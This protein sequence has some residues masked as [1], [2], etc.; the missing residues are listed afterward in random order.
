M[1]KKGFT[2]IELMIV[3][4]IIGI[5]AAIAVPKF[6]ELIKKS[7]EGA[8]KGTLSSARSALRVYY[9]DN[10]AIYPA[11]P[12]GAN[13]AYLQTALVPKYIGEWPSLHVAPYHPETNTVDAIDGGDPA[14]AD[15]ADDGEWVYV[16]NSG[17]DEWGRL[18]IECYHADLKG[19]V[20]SA[21]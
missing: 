13:I 14:D 11:G 1:K 21:Y 20:W 17:S 3:V 7:R 5:L 12:A 8:L 4:A 10:E 2:L 15:A 18:N 6:A 16:S 9:S 19:A